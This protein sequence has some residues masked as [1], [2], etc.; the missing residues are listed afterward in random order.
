MDKKEARERI[1]KN[2]KD[3]G[4]TSYKILVEVKGRY[5]IEN[6]LVQEWAISR[7]IDPKVITDDWSDYVTLNQALHLGLLDFVFKHA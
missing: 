1:G 2:F 5:L 4:N 7:G 3:I 6:N